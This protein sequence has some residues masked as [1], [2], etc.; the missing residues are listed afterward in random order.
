MDAACHLQN[1]FDLEGED[2]NTKK[3]ITSLVQH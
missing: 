1:C 2:L 3:K